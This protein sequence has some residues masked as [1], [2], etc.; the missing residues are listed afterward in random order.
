MDA[1]VADLIEL[2]SAASAGGHRTC[3]EPGIEAAARASLSTAVGLA[4][5]GDCQQAR[6]LCA[7]VVA[8][9]QPLMTARK[10]LLCITLHALF[11]SRG[12]K[13]LARLVM[14]TSGW[15]IR[16]TLLPHRIVAA[17][18]T[19]SGEQCGRT[20]YTVD[21]GWLARL[22]PDDAFLQRWSEALADGHFGEADG[23]AMNEPEG[24]L[25]PA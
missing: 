15:N 4:R 22:S 18:P 13:L 6:E 16:L 9:A 11:I 8:E 19:S 7:A 3:C 25:E 17:A 2:T 23:I 5:A 14:A 24:H 1:V 10:E 12:F 20:V 21:P